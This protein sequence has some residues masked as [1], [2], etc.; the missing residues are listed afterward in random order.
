MRIIAPQQF[1]QPGGQLLDIDNILL[2]R[3]GEGQHQT[4]I[5]VFELGPQDTRSIQQL[6]AGIHGDPLFAAGHTGTVLRFGTLTAG[7]LVDKGGF[8]HIGNAHHHDLHRPVHSLRGVTLQLFLQ[9]AAGGRNKII[10]A[11]AALAVG[12]DHSHTFAS[13]ISS[14]ALGGLRVCQ[15]H[16]VQHD[17]P[18]LGA[19][20]GI[21]IR[22]P[23][24]HGDT[25]IHDLADSIYQFQIRLD[26]PPG[27]GHMAGIPLNIHFLLVHFPNAP[28]LVISKGSLPLFVPGINRKT[29]LPSSSRSS[30]WPMA[31]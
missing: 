15:I 28:I 22:I 21:D 13:E 12:D 11:L 24:G 27:L 14:P 2:H 30:T 9:H 16:P 26:L 20:D 3:A 10:D 23:A 29:A 31:G 6:Q 18:G 4:H 1:H 25:G 8:S 17:D 5:G 7:D 19:A